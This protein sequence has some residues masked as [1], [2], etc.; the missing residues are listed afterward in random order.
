MYT[1]FPMRNVYVQVNLISCRT[2]T[3]RQYTL[4]I[5]ILYYYVCMLPIII[6]KQNPVELHL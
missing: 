2:H 4:R 1:R 5:L 6:E 3:F